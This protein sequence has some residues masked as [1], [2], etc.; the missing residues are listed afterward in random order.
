V[1]RFNDGYDISEVQMAFNSLELTFRT[2]RR[3]F[4]PP[5]VDG[6]RFAVRGGSGGAV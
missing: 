6:Q 4:G 1:E 3:P 5:I 2:S